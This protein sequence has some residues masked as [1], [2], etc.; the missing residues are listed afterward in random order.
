M[1]VFKNAGFERFARKQRVARKGQGRS[2]GFLTIIL[3]RAA[4]RAFFVYGFAKSDRDN[5]DDHEAALF[6]KAASHVL[7]LS[8]TQ[9]AELIDRGHFSEV[10]VNDEE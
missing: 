10:Q 5:I 9:I 1:K 2:G 7:G 6:K 4:E 3:Y 8:D